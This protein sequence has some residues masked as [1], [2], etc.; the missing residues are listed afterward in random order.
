MGREHAERPERA[1]R[2]EDRELGAPA[3]TCGKKA[4]HHTGSPPRGTGSADLD[5]YRRRECCPGS[6]LVDAHGV[7]GPGHSEVGLTQT[8]GQVDV[9]FAVAGH[10]RHVGWIAGEVADADP[11][12]RV[13]LLFP[14]GG[15]SRRT[16][17]AR[18]P[19]P[20]T[21]PGQRNQPGLDEC[22]GADL[23]PRRRRPGVRSWQE[24]RSGPEQTKPACVWCSSGRRRGWDKDILGRDRL[25]EVHLTDGLHLCLQ[26]RWHVGVASAFRVCRIPR[27]RRRVGDTGNDRTTTVSATTTCRGTRATSGGMRGSLLSTAPARG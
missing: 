19:Q 13:E 4:G 10:D 2:V 20:W 11:P 18:H 1:Q 21:G 12:R 27:V 25:R 7:E 9:A 14:G 23:R 16:P 24:S 5:R 3:P 22:P 8:V 26:N 6:T 17:S 15:S